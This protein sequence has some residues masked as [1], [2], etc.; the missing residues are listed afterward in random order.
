MNVD[1]LL[2]RLDRVRPSG[3]DCWSA[4][5]PAH[6]DRSPSLS[7]RDVGDRVLLHCHSGC[8][9]DAV[10]AAAGIGLHDLF[11][12]SRAP[13]EVAPGITPRAAAAAMEE[14]LLVLAC[15]AADRAAGRQLAQET[16]ERE[17][18]AWQ[19]V[20]RGRELLRRAGA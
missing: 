17:A 1:S 11:A 13:R 6:N 19:R 4:C 2:A 7:I 9:V 5:C 8:T 10:C 15:A 12:D 14:E 3:K 16:R 20:D 18:L